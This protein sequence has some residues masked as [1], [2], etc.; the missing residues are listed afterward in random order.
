[1]LAGLGVIVYAVLLMSSEPRDGTSVKEREIPFNADFTL[2]DHHGVDRTAEDFKGQWLLVFFGFT[3]CPD[4]CPTTLSEIAAVMEG[5]GENRSMVQP[6]FISIDPERDTI[7][8]LAEYLPNFDPGIIGLTGTP[9][10]IAKTA[11]HFF[12]YFEK[13]EGVT[14]ADPYMMGHSSQVLLFDT[15]G[16]FVTTWP[17][18]T[19]AEDILGD[20]MELFS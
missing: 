9:E 1:M 3:N 15:A 14:K 16:A 20:I 8:A 7:D 5:L 11:Q 6:L 13:I 4:V 17:Y 10:Q 19:F 12:V 2:T 18:G